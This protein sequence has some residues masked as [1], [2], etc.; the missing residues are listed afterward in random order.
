MRHQLFATGYSACQYGQVANGAG[1][2]I[3]ATTNPK[4]PVTAQKYAYAAT[5][6]LFFAIALP[7]LSICLSYLRIFYSDK[8]G[9]R[10]IQVL[11]VILVLT[12]VPFF[13]EDLFACKPLEV[14]WTELR[15]QS[16]CLQDLPALYTNGSLNVAVDIALMAILI[17]RILALK[18]NSRQKGALIGIVLLGSFA[19]V[20]GIVR[21]VRVGMTLG[22]YDS[23]TFDPPWDTYD[24]SIWT[25]TEIYVS[26]ICAAAPGVKPLV[27]KIM[28]KLLGTTL[29]SR[30]RTTGGGTNPIELNSKMKR[31]TLGTGGTLHKSVSTTGLTTAHGPYSE[32]GRGTDVESIGDKSEEERYGQPSP[33]TGIIKKS[34]IMVQTSEMRR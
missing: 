32:V 24:V 3:A 5:L 16:K 6:I 34:E 28:P 1:R 31:S 14:Y 26:L 10:L 27:S 23:G 25:S 2:H 7:K 11:M 15:P 18:L 12:I 19:V 4:A 22:K 8:V 20:A 9:R 13:I 29:R 17:P 21:M 30:T 33:G